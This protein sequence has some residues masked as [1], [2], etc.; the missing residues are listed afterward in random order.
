MIGLA[1]ALV[2]VTGA[3]SRP[4]FDTAVVYATLHDAGRRSVALVGASSPVA[5]TVELH[6]SIAMRGGAMTGGTMNGMQMPVMAMHPVS[7]I[8]VPPHGTTALRP[9]GYHIMLLGL[10]R[11]LRA[12]EHFPIT[13]R[14]SDGE[15]VTVS[16]PVEN[17][18]M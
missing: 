14:F 4:A 3:W 12:G 18:A 7:R 13:L 10:R 11:P 5:R 2:S 16:V 6:R 9:G 17:R 8:V 15:R 1:L